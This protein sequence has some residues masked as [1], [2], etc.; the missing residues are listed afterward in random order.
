MLPKKKQA[1]YTPIDKPM[2]KA[3]VMS[4]RKEIVKVASIMIQAGEMRIEDILSGGDDE[5]IE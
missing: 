5:M 4:S 2:K 1:M 3:D